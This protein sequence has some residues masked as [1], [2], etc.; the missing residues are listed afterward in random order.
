MIPRLDG[1]L[2]SEQVAQ[3]ASAIAAMQE[4]DGA[5]PWTTGDEVDVWNHVEAAMALLAGGEAD[6]AHAAYDWCLRSQRADGSWPMRFR[7]GAV[8]NAAT[9]SNMC[10]YLAVGVW[11]HW[12]ICRDRAFVA[13]MWPSVQAGLEVVLGLQLPFGGIAWARDASG[14][15]V[16]DALLT[17]SSSIYHSLVAGI[18]IADLV[19]EQRPDWELAANRLQHAVREHPEKFADKSSFSMD[20]Y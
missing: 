11:H 9:E 5:I 10:A 14:A 13:R 19:G 18:A 7:D 8:T 4:A 16:A 12:L 6:A 15:P 17:G 2:T 3:T 20:W 1:V